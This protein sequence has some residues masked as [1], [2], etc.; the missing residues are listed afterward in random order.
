MPPTH[1]PIHQ[2]CQ[3]TAVR[4]KAASNMI[5]HETKLS[6]NRIQSRVSSSSKSSIIVIHLSIYLSIYLQQTGQADNHAHTQPLSLSIF[7]LSSKHLHHESLLSH[8]LSLLVSRQTVGG[9]E[10][11]RWIAGWTPAYNLLR[12]Q[13]HTIKHNTIHDDL[14]FPG[15]EEQSTTSEW[16]GVMSLP[17]YLLC[18]KRC[19]VLALALGCMPS[20]AH[21]ITLYHIA[22][23][24]IASHRI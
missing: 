19:L 22:S 4:G 13:G 1:P 6:S 23:Y 8:S 12:T 15:L 24:H 3:R 21:H 14:A 7:Q 11:H 16:V 5:R 17:T 20:T 2:F 10:I 18:W 9:H